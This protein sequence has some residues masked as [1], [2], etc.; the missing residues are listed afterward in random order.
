[1]TIWAN[2]KERRLSPSS[3]F[4][5]FWIETE[6]LTHSPLCPCSNKASC[7]ELL[8]N[9]SYSKLYYYS[10]FQPRA[11]ISCF[12]TEAAK[13]PP[14]KISTP[15]FFFS[16]LTL[17]STLLQLPFTVCNELWAPKSDLCQDAQGQKRKRRKRAEKAAIGRE[18]GTLFPAALKLQGVGEESNRICRSCSW[19]HSS[20]VKSLTNAPHH[21]HFP[22]PGEQTFPPRSDYWGRAQAENGTAHTPGQ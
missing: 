17:S 2:T 20:L 1:M 8:G 3:K 4:T 13:E 22:C 10:R 9:P 15:T 19:R 14:K 5:S 11:I 12:K 18:R 16:F 21:H 6:T 7:K